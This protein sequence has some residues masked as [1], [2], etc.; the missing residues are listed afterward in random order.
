MARSQEAGNSRVRAAAAVHYTDRATADPLKAGQVIRTLDGAYHFI[1]YVNSSG[2]FAVPLLGSVQDINGKAVH[3]ATKG[4]A[5]SVHSMVERVAPLSMGG[6]SVEYKR[7]VTMSEH[8]GGEG[9]A[10]GKDRGKSKGKG[11]VAA[12]AQSTETEI[13]LDLVGTVGTD[14]EMGASFGDFE[15]AIDMDA[16]PAGGQ[17]AASESETATTPEGKGM[18]TATATRSHKANGK[19]ANGKAKAA[20]REKVT[21]TV[22]KC[23]CACG[24]ETTGHFLPGHDAR[25]HGWIKKLADGRIEPK[26]IPSSVVKHLELQQTKTGYRAMKPH[27]YKSA[28]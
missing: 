19:A 17:L 23:A 26:D 28:D 20:K 1:Q 16:E 18:A 25:L 24:G 11:K 5:I 27:F 3:F 13:D 15:A 8:L 14:A 2:A 9:M 7:Y 10:K 6:N 21:K 4:R 12:V 22:R